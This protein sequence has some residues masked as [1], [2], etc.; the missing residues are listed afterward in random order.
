M[1]TNDFF[2]PAL[3]FLDR[4][5]GEALTTVKMLLLVP[6]LPNLK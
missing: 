2:S 1:L 3:A 6:F 5:A 4:T